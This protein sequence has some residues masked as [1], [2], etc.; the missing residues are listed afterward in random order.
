MT[1]SGERQ[2]PN[3]NYKLSK[4]DNMLPDEAEGLTFYY[5]RQRRLDKAPQSVRDLYKEQPKNHGIL[6]SLIADR[7]RKILFFSIVVL[8]IMIWIISFLGYFDSSYLLEGNRIKIS[9]TIFEG[10]TI[11]SIKKTQNNLLRS[12]SGSVD[13]AVSIPAEIEGEY[14][15]FYH[16]I[17]FTL[18]KEEEYSFVVPFDDPLLLMA[19]Q[20]E[21]SSLKLTFNPN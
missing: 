11:V 10:A 19:L 4:P 3:A 20:T 15:V 6:R 9:G 8:C 14:P 1:D 13:I 21:N 16:R 7:P 5:N 12:Y 18:E 17:F 2:R